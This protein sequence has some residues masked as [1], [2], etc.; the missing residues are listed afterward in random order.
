[1]TEKFEDNTSFHEEFPFE[2]VD[3]AY[4]MQRSVNQDTVVDKDAELSNKNKKNKIIEKDSQQR[5][6]KT[7][8]TVTAKYKDTSTKTGTSETSRKELLI[9][10]F[11]VIG[12]VLLA[13][14][15]AFPEEFFGTLLGIPLVYLWLSGGSKRKR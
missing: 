11:V 1:M 13:L 9:A 12:T 2:I 3:A 10:L 7:T 15:I 8:N 14:M 6:Q 4:A 5:T